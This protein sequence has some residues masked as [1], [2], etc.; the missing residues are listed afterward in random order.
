MAKKLSAQAVQKAVK[1]LKGWKYLPSH[2]AIVKEYK[3]KD[4]VEAFRFMTA[5]AL[6]AEKMD[7]H[8]EWSN[9]YNKVMV[10]L[11]T[12]DAGGLTELDIKLAKAMDSLRK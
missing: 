1:S 2:G 10:A 12:H 3:F 8:P 9:V 11:Y 4:F 5:S 6:V 7:H